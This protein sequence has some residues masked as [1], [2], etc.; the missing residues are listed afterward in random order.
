M[1]DHDTMTTN[2]PR[3]AITTARTRPIHATATVIPI[4]L[5][6]LLLREQDTLSEEQPTVISPHRRHRPCARPKVTSRSTRITLQHHVF[7]LPRRNPTPAREG[8]TTSGAT[9]VGQ[10]AVAGAASL[11]EV[12][13]A[14]QHM[15]AP[16]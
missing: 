14:G 12:A 1:I 15:T 16:S 11:H 7:P 8:V 2:A 9:A 10:E 3:V 13:E 6:P 5:L 4:P